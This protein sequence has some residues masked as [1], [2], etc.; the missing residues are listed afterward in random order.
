MP[1]AAPARFSLSDC[2]A[3]IFAAI[4]DPCFIRVYLW[5]N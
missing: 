2:R 3:A 1:A 5:L 4:D